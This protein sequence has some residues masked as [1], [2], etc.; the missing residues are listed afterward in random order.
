LSAK[1][2]SNK[3][4]I[5][6]AGALRLYV[7]L[8][9]KENDKSLQSE[10]AKGIWN[11]AFTDECKEKI[12]NEPGCLKGILKSFITEKTIPSCYL[13]LTISRD[14]NIVNNTMFVMLQNSFMTESR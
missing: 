3:Q 10:A 12:K 2:D 6:E 1:N 8:L 7:E 5:V 11:L 4:K 9:K 13:I 14:H